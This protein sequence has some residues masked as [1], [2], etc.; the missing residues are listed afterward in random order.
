M[1]LTVSVENASH[2]CTP[3]HAIRA[4]EASLDEEAVAVIREGRDLRD[5][6]QEALRHFTLQ[7]MRQSGRLDDAD[8]EAFVTAGF[9]RA[10]ILDVILAVG[11]KTLSNYTAFLA[12]PPLDPPMAAAAF[13]AGR[14]CA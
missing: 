6:R 5:P 11:L 2:Y 7:M 14:P 3:A 9:S 12:R 8:L 10:N 4:R 1:L 13:A